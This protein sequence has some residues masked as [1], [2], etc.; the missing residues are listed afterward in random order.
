MDSPGFPALLEERALPFLETW[1]PGSGVARLLAESR[2]PTSVCGV[3]NGSSF[4][5]FGLPPIAI[6]EDLPL[7]RDNRFYRFWGV[8]AYETRAGSYG[9]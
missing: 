3:M 7:A 1:R 4:D 2:T 5:G 6:V 8:V 9:V